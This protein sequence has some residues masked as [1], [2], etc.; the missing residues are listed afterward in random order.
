MKSLSIFLLGTILGGAAASASLVYQYPFLIEAIARDITESRHLAQHR[1]DPDEDDDYEVIATAPDTSAPL[2]LR[3]AAPRD[4]A[5]SPSRAPDSRIADVPPATGVPNV[6]PESTD[7]IL[8]ASPF[9]EIT[10]PAPLDQSCALPPPKAGTRTIALGTYEGRKTNADITFDRAANGSA[11]WLV[12]VEIASGDD[13]LWLVM[14]AFEPVIWNFQGEVDRIE[15]VVLVDGVSSAGALGLPEGR[16]TAM[17]RDCF[18]ETRGP[19]FFTE[20]SDSW[21]VLGAVEAAIGVEIDDIFAQYTLDRAA[22][23][24][25]A[26]SVA[27]RSAFREMPELHYVD[28]SDLVLTAAGQRPEL[29]P[30]SIGIAQLIE[31]G[32]LR[33]K[34]GHERYEILTHIPALPSAARGEFTLARD[35]APPSQ[36]PFM[37]CV[38]DWRGRPVQTDSPICR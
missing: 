30:G 24:E 21:Q 37:A 7:T 33:E 27:R 4:P 17:G 11:S 22:L 34:S 13:P 14:S 9:A 3:D 38:R 23:P 10:L 6:A 31:A 25:G 28:P 16:V 20:I 1:H 19:V 36:I 12:D 5:S 18:T 35:V 2:P 29:L 8:A 32:A 15:H 26:L